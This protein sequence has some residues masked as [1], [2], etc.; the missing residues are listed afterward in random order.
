[1]EV[2]LRTVIAIDISLKRAGLNVTLFTSSCE[3]CP[4]T[5]VVFAKVL[6]TSSRA[7]PFLLPLTSKAFQVRNEWL[8][9]TNCVSPAR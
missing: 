4:L 6:G 5:E 8:R 2:E 1:M 7:A 3:T 9:G